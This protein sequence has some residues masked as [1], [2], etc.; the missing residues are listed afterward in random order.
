ML[1]VPSSQV[2]KFIYSKI[3]SKSHPCCQCFYSLFPDRHNWLQ[4]LDT[5]IRIADDKPHSN[6]S[7]FSCQM[8]EVQSRLCLITVFHPLFPR[9]KTLFFVV[10]V[11]FSYTWNVAG[12]NRVGVRVFHQVLNMMIH[13]NKFFLLDGI[14]PIRV[15]TCLLNG[16]SQTFPGFKRPTTGWVL[17]P[18]LLPTEKFRRWTLL[19]YVTRSA[20]HNLNTSVILC[21]EEETMLEIGAN[22]KFSGKF[23][24]TWLSSHTQA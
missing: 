4:D 2:L 12:W 22:F 8:E 18:F 1:P 21:W 14:M 20:V 10:L 9:Y 15:S 5:F 3:N 23:F 7:V 13:Q 6:V 24:K 19:G 17:W 16:L 11:L